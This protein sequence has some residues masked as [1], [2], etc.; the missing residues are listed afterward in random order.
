MSSTEPTEPKVEET[1]VEETKP[2]ET[3]E[4][5]IDPT[6]QRDTATNSSTPNAQPLSVNLRQA[7]PSNLTESGHGLGEASLRDVAGEALDKYGF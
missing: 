1:K 4:V 6:R 3:T 5:N 2:A 7:G